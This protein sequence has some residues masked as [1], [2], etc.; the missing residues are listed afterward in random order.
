MI[1]PCPHCQAEIEIDAETQAALSGQSHFA[2]PACQGAV[3]VPGRSQ[4]P[5]SAHRGINRNLLILGALALLVLGGIG[6]FLA[7]QKA[8]DTN[9]VVQNIRNEILNNTYFTQIIADGVTTKADLE[10]IADIR[11]YGDDFIGISKEAL[12]W[13][14]ALDLAKRTGASV[15]AVDD[16]SIKSRDELVKWLGEVFEPHLSS[17][18]WVREQGQPGVLASAEILAVKKTDG[19]RK[20]FFHWKTNAKYDSAGATKERPFVNSLGMK[21]V[22]VPGTKVLMCIHETRRQDYALYAREVPNVNEDWKAARHEGVPCG[23]KVNHPV[24]SVNW[25][26]AGDFC[27]WLSKREGKT[28]RLPTDQEWSYAAGIGQVETWEPTT[29]PATVVKNTVQYPWGTEWPQPENCGNYKDVSHN[30]QSTPINSKYLGNYADGFPT[31]ASVMSFKPNA[32]GLYDLGGNLWEWCEDWYDGERYGLRV[33]RGASWLDTATWGPYPGA[34]LSSFRARHTPNIRYP[35]HGFRVVMELDKGESKSPPVPNTLGDPPNTTRR[36]IDLMPLVDL[37]RDASQG[38]WSLTGEGISLAE[39]PDST[40]RIQF[41]HPIATTEYDYEIDI[42]YQ[43]PLM[44]HRLGFPTSGRRMEWGMNV[45]SFQA[46]PYYL[47]FGLD[48]VPAAHAKEAVTYLPQ[49]KQGGRHTHIVKVR[50]GELA[51]FF[52]GEQVVQWKGDTTRFKQPP[53]PIRDPRFPDFFIFRGGIVIHQA[54]IIEF[55]PL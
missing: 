29:T 51:A 32:L 23:D 39:T 54:K 38:A 33:L 3:A 2:C 53:R 10:A 55:V 5:S 37:S 11:P 52:D 31:T 43:N 24:V 14:Q 4:A 12:T 21:F 34:L 35:F 16:T 27:A 47:F 8:G 25:F 50:Q 49:L 13:E 44:E 40:P 41:P 22:P 26:D 28:Y 19:T 48:G 46:K 6:I 18:V 7:S 15:L 30:T 36:V 45:F 20:A 1:T 17:P 42:S 9:T